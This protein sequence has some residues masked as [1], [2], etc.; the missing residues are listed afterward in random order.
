MCASTSALQNSAF[1]IGGDL[2]PLLILFVAGRLKAPIY[3]QVWSTS[4]PARKVQR[5]VYITNVSIGGALVGWFLLLVYLHYVQPGWFGGLRHWG[6]R[7]ELIG[8][9]LY[10]VP[11]VIM[12]YLEWRRQWEKYDVEFSPSAEAAAHTSGS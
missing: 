9:L 11:T 10:I 7:A 4:Q 8:A 12:S 1:L 6:T 3:R 2:L 5:I